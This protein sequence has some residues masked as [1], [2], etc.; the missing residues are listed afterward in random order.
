MVQTERTPTACAQ[1]CLSLG[2]TKHECAFPLQSAE[3]NLSA[4]FTGW[5]P[6]EAQTPPS[7]PM[8]SGEGTPC[9][10][11]SGKNWEWGLGQAAN[12]GSTPGGPEQQ[13]QRDLDFFINRHE[14][15]PLHKF[16]LSKK[17]LLN[18]K[19]EPKQRSWEGAT[20]APGPTHS[21]DLNR[22]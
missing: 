12:P 2:R 18:V 8:R 3:L 6:P 15:D 20:L 17:Q 21:P 7:L 5:F 10:F 9:G 13:A 19:K 14:H 22:A 1:V 16:V 4:C 11:E